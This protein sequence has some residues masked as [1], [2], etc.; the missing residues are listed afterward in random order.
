MKSFRHQFSECVANGT[1]HLGEIKKFKNH[2][3]LLPAF[4]KAAKAVADALKENP[5][6]GFRYYVC[7]KFGGDCNSKNAGCVAMRKNLDTKP[8]PA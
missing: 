4:G 8:S 6:F 3:E 7:T 5:E 2:P 1:S